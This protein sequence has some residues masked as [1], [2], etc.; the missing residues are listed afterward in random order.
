MVQPIQKR[1]R[2]YRACIPDDHLRSLTTIGVMLVMPVSFTWNANDFL[3]FPLIKFCLH[4]IGQNYVTW[5]LLAERKAGK[6]R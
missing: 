4:L 6:D 5:S 1:K 2:L 3:E